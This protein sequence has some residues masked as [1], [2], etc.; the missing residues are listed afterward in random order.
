MKFKT[1]L[2]VVTLLIGAS[3]PVLAQ[4]PGAPDT[5]IL[6]LTQAPD[7]NGSQLN[8]QLDLYA[9]SDEAIIGAT[10][11]FKWDN[12]NLQMTNAT[13]SALITARGNNIGPFFY[14]SNDI[15]V[16]NANKRFLFGWT[17][18]PFPG[19]TAIPADAS[20]RRLWA[21]YFFTL[22]SWTI[23]DSIV[24]DTLTYSAGTAFLFVT[25]GSVSFQPKWPGKL[26]VYDPNKP[27]GANLVVNP[28]TLNFSGVQGG[29]NPS[30]Q[31]FTIFSDG[32]PLDYTL[33]EDAAWLGA[34]PGSGTTPDTIT[35]SVN[36]AG[37]PIGTVTDTIEVTSTTA[38][39]SPR[40]VIVSLAVAAPKILDISPDTVA[41]EATQGEPNPT[42]KKFAVA[43][44]GGAA[45]SYS[46]L[47]TAGWIQ[48]NK[49]GGTTPDSVQVAVLIA[50]L[51]PGVHLDSIRVTALEANNSPQYAFVKL[52]LAA[53]PKYLAVD[54]DTLKFVA[55][56]G[57]ITPDSQIFIVSD[58][59][60][61]GLAFTAT[62]SADWFTINKSAG[63]TPSAVGV[64][65]DMTTATEGDYFDSIT[66]ASGDAANSPV[67]E[68]VSLTVG[69][70][71]N[72]PPVLGPVADS[73]TIDECD[74]LV[75]TFTATD[76]DGDSLIMSLTGQTGTLYDNMTFFDSGNGT[77]VLVFTPSIDQAGEYW[78]VIE[79][80]DGTLSDTAAFSI[81]VLNCAP[82]NQPP[83]LG[84]VADTTIDEC[85][86]LTIIFTATDPDDDVV[87]FSLDTL[88]D[89]MTFNTTDSFASLV[90]TPSLDQAGVYPMVV[91]ASDGEL[92][93]SA[94]FVITVLGCAPGCVNMILSDTAFWFVD[95]ID[96]DYPV[97]VSVFDTL[98]VTSSGAEFC[99]KVVCDT[100][101]QASWY[102]IRPDSGCT[103][104]D[105]EIEVNST[106]LPEG[107]YWTM[108]QI[109][110]DSTVCEPNPQ[111]FTVHLILVDTTTPP[112]SGG[113]TLTVATVVG[114]RGSQ[115]VV[116]V[117]FVNQCDLASILVWLQWHGGP[118]NLD[119]VSWW[120]SRMSHFSIRVDS[121][122][123]EDDI[124]FLLG[125]DDTA[126]VPPGYGNF[127]NLHFTID[128]DAPAD[129][130][131]IDLE[132]IPAIEHPI[133]TEYCN[134]G[135]DIIQPTFTSGGIFVNDSANYVCGYVVDT[136][137]H[138]IPGATV[139]LWTDFPYGYPE[140]TAFSDS[141][142]FFAFWNFSVPFELWG[143]HD[144]Y[145]PQLV[146][147]V[148][149]P[150]TG[151][152]IELT[153]VDLPYA[154]IEWVN[155][156]CSTNT[157]MGGP[158]PAGSVIDAYDPDGIHCGTFQVTMPG[159]YG[160]LV[161]YRDDPYEPGD[162]G[163]EPGDAIRVF[164]NGIE[165][166]THGDDPI[167]TTNGDFRQVCLEAG[168]LV[169]KT[170]DLAEGWNLVS[171]NLDTEDDYILNVLNSIAPCVELVMGFEQ[172]GLTYDPDLPEFSNLW[173]TDHMSGYWIKTSC[174]V[175]LEITGAPVP[176]S[177]PMPLTKG[178]NLVSYLPEFAMPTPDALATV[179]DHLVVAL[180]YDPV[181]SGLVY[182]PSGGP[183]NTLVEMEPCF[184]YWVKVT[185]DEE[186][187]YPGAG[188]L[189]VASHKD[190]GPAISAA[191]PD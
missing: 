3:M 27:Q 22:S 94:A 62:E 136:G 70:P 158:L 147:P 145:Y 75:M 42:P 160:P 7:A 88:Y 46:L 93:D 126:L 48:L 128:A 186:L 36:M 85:D 95:T 177:T 83:V 115:V 131:P 53:A 102:T 64:F 166:V 2:L 168:Q 73:T 187:V 38:L 181:D 67:F 138:P 8:V 142:G 167:W 40:Q 117:T 178:W 101:V 92:W 32:D 179:H 24:F 123:N 47:E 10:S 141:T 119:S 77:A 87:T 105:I 57:G 19:N 4:G 137:G 72:R 74:T 11:G 182:Q 65:I 144:G 174:P 51:T 15:N 17:L 113:D 98:Q 133:F 82:A 25:T 111:Y 107:H 20:G 109:L 79:A 55:T 159:W 112:P 127:V 188:P 50:I 173:L 191:A 68:Y 39:N 35:V 31:T 169:T 164:V 143:Y 120:D 69:P 21:S 1:L 106:N 97:V 140:M 6:V 63:A 84:P 71:A 33:T 152:M 104:R 78:L 18:L 28:T 163:A 45:L 86:T 100:L 14:E 171:W 52:T 156:Y 139:E 172:G 91:R 189:I 190:A 26:V 150:P 161:I 122:Y 153:P 180:G 99:F 29:P 162:Q 34:A 16:T 49:S 183:F 89:N 61:P 54:P 12:P 23:N 129:W 185:Q 13:A 108:C 5:V 59:G 116:P 148:I 81:T 44:L 149:F 132:P 124:V 58:S 96:W 125:A 135:F 170:C 9:Y 130:Y 134:Q 80:S 110:G 184:G 157:Y 56:E 66:I 30:D 76:P 37:L 60:S 121:I 118:F 103:P 90:F 165:A 175:T 114:F 146:D 176:A 41:F 154:S 155:F 151:V 43:E